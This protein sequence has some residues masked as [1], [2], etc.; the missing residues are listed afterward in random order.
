MDL[1][2]PRGP[3]SMAANFPMGRRDASRS[4]A[5]RDLP[6]DDGSDEDTYYQDS[7]DSRGYG[8][9]RGPARHSYAG[10]SEHGGRGYDGSRYSAAM[11]DNAY[12]DEGRDYD[13]RENTPRSEE[14]QYRSR[15]YGS[16]YYE[17]RGR[18]NHGRRSDSR[19]D[20]HSR[21]PPR[22][23]SRS[24][25]PPPGPGIPSDTI[26]LEG[27]PPGVLADE[28]GSLP[29]VFALRLSSIAPGLHV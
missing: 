26:I 12:G 4:P 7:R 25:S 19:S 20:S 13:E 18:D 1:L 17:S 23:R 27:L 29:G 6:Y 15:H 9:S 24:G 16:R 14:G 5:R 22:Y 21:S 10:Y 11:Y 8:Y 3:L 2:K 28:V